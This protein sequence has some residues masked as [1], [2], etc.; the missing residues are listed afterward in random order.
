MLE[1]RVDRFMVGVMKSITTVIVALAVASVVHADMTPLSPLEGESGQPLP[2]CDQTVPQQPTVFGQAA[3]FLGAV[4]LDSLPVGFLPEVKSQ[5]G[6]VGPAKPPE[7]LADRQNSLALC[8]YALLGLGLCRSV[9]LV[10]KLHLG[11]IPDWYHSGGP[12]QIG[13][14]F[15]ISPDCLT[16]APVVCFIQPDSTAVVGDTLLQCCW[17]IVVSLW[18]QSQYTPCVLASRGPPY[19]S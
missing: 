12:S 6:D 8:L 10:R 2:V 13:H 18:R 14:S 3:T 1:F 15:T 7:I 17:R 19:M 11:C 5:V 4:D 16:A 9:P